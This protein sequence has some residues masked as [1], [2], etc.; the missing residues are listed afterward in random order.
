[1][2][3]ALG[4]TGN[5][6]QSQNLLWLG[7]LAG[8]VV[9]SYISPVWGLALSGVILGVICWINFG[10]PWWHRRRLREPSEAWFIDAE[11]GKQILKKEFRVSANSEA[12][13][14]LEHMPKLKFGITELSFGFVGE[15]GEKPEPTE[16]FNTFIREGAR[17]RGSPGD[18]ADHLVDRKANYHILEN[19]IFTPSNAYT[20]GFKI[21]TAKPGRYPVRWYYFTDEGEG[22][23]GKDLTL[24]VE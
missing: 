17:K 5:S 16:Y 22:R 23:V 9:V 24:I 6:T 15:V 21:A 4:T 13:I 10:V 7:G 19:R 2:K 1:M 3:I 18:N 12:A 20:I 14:Q 11:N 8:A